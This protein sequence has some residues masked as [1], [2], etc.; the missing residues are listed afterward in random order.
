MKMIQTLVC[1]DDRMEYQ[2]HMYA[3]EDFDREYLPDIR[4]A[5]FRDEN[6]LDY[7]VKMLRNSFNAKVYLY[8]IERWPT[9]RYLI[10]TNAYLSEAEASEMYDQL[11]TGACAR[12]S[13]A[14]TV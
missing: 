3:D 12:K 10:T 7:M 9:L 11:N 13:S 2:T 1:K 5:G 8:K 4:S 14:A 6:V